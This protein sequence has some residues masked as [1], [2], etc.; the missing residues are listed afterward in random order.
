MP[1]SKM[2]L[3][4]PHHPCLKSWPTTCY[5]LS[6]ISWSMLWSVGVR[7]SSPFWLNSIIKT[8]VL[9]FPCIDYQKRYAYQFNT[10]YPKIDAD[11]YCFQEVTEEYIDLLE[12]SEFYKSGGFTHT[13]PEQDRKDKH[14]PMILSRLPFVCLYNKDRT[15]IWLFERDDVNFIVVN[16]H[17]TAYED[18]ADVRLQEIR[19]L[20]IILKFRGLQREIQQKYLE[21]ITDAIHNKNVFLLGDLNLHFPGESRILEHSSFNDCWLERRS[22]FDGLSWDAQT[23]SMT[24]WMLPFDNRRMRL[25][26]ICIKDSTQ[27]D[28]DDIELI[29]KENAGRALLSPSDHYGI[30]AT[31]IKSKHGFTKINNFFKLEFSKWERN[32]TG[33]RSISTI[34]LYRYIT[35]I[36][37]LI[38]IIYGIYRIIG[39]FI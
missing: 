12:G 15:V 2:K 37:L 18:K 26:R 30:A 38:V 29:G 17:F 4:L 23:N 39:I 33:Y 34:K 21:K 35:L 7:I 31:F 13:E 8:S 6:K 28:L 5:T 9:W 11:I 22:H 20:N 36:V 3:N 16:A 1:N 25:D 32:V 10:M 14:F 19:D 24:K 27:I